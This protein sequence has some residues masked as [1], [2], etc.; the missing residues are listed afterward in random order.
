M[1][2]HIMYLKNMIN[3]IYMLKG[4]YYYIIITHIT[5]YILKYT[6]GILMIYMLFRG[7]PRFPQAP[8]L[9]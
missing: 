4:L 7:E 8:L 5:E 2:R 1:K 9:H 3:S 6:G